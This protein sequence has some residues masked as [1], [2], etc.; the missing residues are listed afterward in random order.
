MQPQ[1]CGINGYNELLLTEYV[2]EAEELA[3]EVSV[4][5][6]VVVLQVRVEVVQQQL[7]LLSLLRLSATV[8]INTDVRLNI[9]FGLIAFTYIIH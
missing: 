6:E 7:L 3:E 9:I 1:R 4:G 5:P 8:I 2:D